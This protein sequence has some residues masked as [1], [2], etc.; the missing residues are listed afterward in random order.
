M[1]RTAVEIDVFTAVADSRRREI[2]AILAHRETPV[3]EIVHRLRV[4]QPL[5]SKHLRVLR[6][7]RAVSI[8]R[9]GRQR[10]YRINAEALRPVYDWA[11]T[12][13]KF[14]TKHVDRIKERAEQAAK[15]QANKEK[16][17]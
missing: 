8:R 6:K 2:L 16:P 17:S 12:F 10:F 5:V 15:Q 7:V 13:E 4:A 14:W 3:N 11:A 9:A 1:P